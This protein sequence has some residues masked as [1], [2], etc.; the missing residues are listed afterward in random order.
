MESNISNNIKYTFLFN[1]NAQ[2]HY[3]QF[4]K[5]RGQHRQPRKDIRAQWRQ[6]YL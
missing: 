6:L 5:T 2:V 4:A 1:T 3:I